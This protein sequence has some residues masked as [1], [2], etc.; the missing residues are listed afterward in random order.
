MNNHF[1]PGNPPPH[2]PAGDPALPWKILKRTAL[3]RDERQDQGHCLENGGLSGA[4]ITQD[5]VLIGDLIDGTVLEFNAQF[6]KPFE[7][8]KMN[9]FDLHLKILPMREHEPREPW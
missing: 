8:L 4:V 2:E 3:G 1:D 5:Q 9:T 7:V 6:I